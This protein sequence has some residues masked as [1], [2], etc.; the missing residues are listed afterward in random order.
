M[1]ERELIQSQQTHTEPA[2]RQ[3]AAGIDNHLARHIEG[4]VARQ[5]DS[6]NFTRKMWAE[7]GEFQ[8]GLKI[9]HKLAY[10]TMVF[11]GVMLMWYGTWGLVAMIPL[12]K[13]PAVALATGV[14]LLALTGVLYNKLT[15]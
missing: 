14:A 1:Q 11:L 10:G 6:L 4:E 7:V 8:R 2:Q 3:V 15:G 12:L 13:M 9:H 5:L